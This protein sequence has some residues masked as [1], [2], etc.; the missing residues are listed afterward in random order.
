MALHGLRVE[1]ARRGA[2]RE[3]GG[4]AHEFARH[5]ERRTGGD[6]DPRHREAPGI[7]KSFDHAACIGQDG[8]FVFDQRVGRQAALADAYAH[9]AA[10]RVKAQ[11][12]F[13]TGMD[14]VVEAHVVRKQI[15]MI[16]RR[17]ATRQHQLRHPDFRGYICCICRQTRPDG[18]QRVEPREQIG[19]L[20]ERPRQRLKQVMMGV[21]EPWQHH[22]STAIDHQ[23]CGR[24]RH[25]GE[26]AYRD[27][28][29]VADVD[30]G[31]AQFASHCVHRRQ[32]MDVADEQRGHPVKLAPRRNARFCA[33]RLV[34]GAPSGRWR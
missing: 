10:G 18:I 30:R 20:R 24:C 29:V 13:A 7:M 14:R 16:A 12:H 23:V 33:S 26:A 17:R 3:R 32:R 8:V 11:A 19:V 21:D 15:Q 28:G 5:R 34:P 2:Q 6:S 25:V 4:I 9:C 22:V 31:I 27:D 1:V